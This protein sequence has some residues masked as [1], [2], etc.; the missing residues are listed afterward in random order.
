MMEKQGYGG[1]TQEHLQMRAKTNW[2]PI[3][4]KDRQ[5]LIQEVVQRVVNKL[6]SIQTMMEKLGDID[7]VEEETQ[8]MME[9]M[10][11]EN[12]LKLE[13]QEASAKIAAENAPKKVPT[14]GSNAR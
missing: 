12:K 11:F 7:D 8:K 5:Q 10:E 2:Y 9:W 6:G 3:L 13:Q 4:P 1:I 14:G